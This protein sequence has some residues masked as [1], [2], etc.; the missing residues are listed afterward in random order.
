MKAQSLM[1]NINP[2]VFLDFKPKFKHVIKYCSD[3]NKRNIK[4]NQRPIIRHVDNNK[5]ITQERR[6]IYR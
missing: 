5:A 4:N 1:Q 2:L 3:H 6:K